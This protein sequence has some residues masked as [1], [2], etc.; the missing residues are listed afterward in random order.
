MCFRVNQDTDKDTG[1]GIR[2]ISQEFRDFVD[3]PEF[4]RQLALS[5]SKESIYPLGNIW[6]VRQQP[7]TYKPEILKTIWGLL[8]N[9]PWV[10][11][12]SKG[13]CC[14]NA[15]ADTIHSKPT[16]KSAIQNK[17]AL[18]PA[19]AFFEW[20]DGIH[21]PDKKKHLYQIERKDG[22]LF[23]FAGLWE[24]HPKFGFSSTIVTVDP[25][26]QVWR[27]AHHDRSPLVLEPEQFKM[28]LDPKLTEW[29]VIKSM[30]GTWEHGKLKIEKFK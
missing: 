4:K 28:W 6:I 13:R 16:F 24:H 29:D 12:K 23:W 25:M 19:R 2:L 22:E 7:E 26:K 3:S 14:Y 1:K 20:S 8:P 27:E 5:F 9:R 15:R 18:V 21:E 30:L 17:R 11:E 10:Q